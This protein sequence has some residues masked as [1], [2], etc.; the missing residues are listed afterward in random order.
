VLCIRDILVRIR[1][2]G[3]APLTYGSG[4]GSGSCFFRQWQRRCQQKISLFQSFLLLLEGSFTS[5]FKDK[6]SNRNHKI[7]EIKGFSGCFCFMME[8]SGSGSRRLIDI[9]ILWIR[10]R[11]RIRTHNADRQNVIKITLD[12]KLIVLTLLTG[13]R[14]NEWN[15]LNIYNF[16]LSL[17]HLPLQQMDG[18]WTPLKDSKK[19]ILCGVIGPRRVR[20]CQ[21][22]VSAG[23]LAE[24]CVQHSGYLHAGKW[25][26]FRNY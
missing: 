19:P 10:I 11:I 23:Q 18:G 12:Q 7:V 5:I 2:R 21:L 4:F 8:G 9:R 22:S 16:S 3:S 1:V 13:S 24:L 15:I 6:K 26:W 14:I 25:V 20:I 17:P